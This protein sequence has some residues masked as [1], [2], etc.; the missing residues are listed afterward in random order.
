[1]IDI[2]FPPMIQ[3]EVPGSPTEPTVLVNAY[4]DQGARRYLANQVEIAH[5]FVAVTSTWINRLRLR[6]AMAQALRP[7]LETANLSL[8]SRPG[9]KRFF[10]G[11]TARPRKASYAVSPDRMALDDAALVFTLARA[12]GDF[13]VLAVQRCLGIDRTDAQRWVRT[14]RSSGLL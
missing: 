12:T 8:L 2:N 5:P 4:F 3:L 10:H 11:S 13:P 1:M 9:A 6:S 14:L 7:H